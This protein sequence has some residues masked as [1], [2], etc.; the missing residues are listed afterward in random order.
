MSHTSFHA[1][2]SYLFI[3][4]FKLDML[5]GKV[6][7][8]IVLVVAQSLGFATNSLEPSLTHYLLMIC[9]DIALSSFGVCDGALVDAP[10]RTQD[11]QFCC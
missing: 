10:R 3:D 5:S 8:L 4:F 6:T 2:Y 9:D 1:C 7:V 11:C